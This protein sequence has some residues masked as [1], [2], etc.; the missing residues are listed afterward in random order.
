V[1]IAR[2]RPDECLA[3]MSRRADLLVV[4]TAHGR[5]RLAFGSVAASVV[6]HATCEVAVVPTAD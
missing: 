3:V 1:E 6:E 4:G 5:S 2:C